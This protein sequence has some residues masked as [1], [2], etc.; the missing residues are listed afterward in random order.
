MGEI[1]I[2]QDRDDV[3]FIPLVEVGCKDSK[4]RMLVFVDLHGVPWY[5]PNREFVITNCG[6][7]KNHTFGYIIENMSRQGAEDLPFH[8]VMLIGFASIEDANQAYDF[9]IAQMRLEGYF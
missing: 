9:A 8:E 4:E 6:L 3:V 2:Y 5:S 1:D 7:V